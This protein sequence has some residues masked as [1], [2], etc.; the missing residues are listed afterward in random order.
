L[1]SRVLQIQLL[2]K[3]KILTIEEQLVEALSKLK[4]CTEHPAWRNLVEFYPALALHEYMHNAVAHTEDVVR[5]FANFTELTYEDY[6]EVVNDSD[7]L[8]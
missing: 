2:H 6:R 8:R 3:E 1:A 4:A 7:V 5:E